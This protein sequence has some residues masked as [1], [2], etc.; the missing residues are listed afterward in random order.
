[1]AVDIEKVRKSLE[2]CPIK[3]VGDGKF[4][5][6]I[7]DERHVRV[8]VPVEGLH[9]NHVGIVYAGT[10]FT[11]MELAAG[12]IFMCTYGLD[13][14]VPIVSNF[15]ISFL[16]P[17]K[18]DLVAEIE[19]TEEEAAERIKPIRERGRG[20]MPVEITLRANGIGVGNHVVYIAYNSEMYF[21]ILTACS[22]IGAVF[23]PISWRMC[24]ESIIELVDATDAKVLFVSK[25]FLEQLET[26][27]HSISGERKIIVIDDVGED[28]AAYSGCLAYPNE[29]ISSADRSGEGC[30]MQIYTSG[31]TS[32]PKGVMLSDNAI[33]SHALGHLTDICQTGNSVYMCVLPLFH[34]SSSGAIAT[35]IAGATVVVLERFRPKVYLKTIEKYKATALSLTPSMFS[36]LLDEIDEGSYDLT[37]V[38]SVIYGA[39]PILAKYIRKANEKL[40]C[41]FYQL[42]GMSEMGP[43]I[44]LL[45]A[46]DHRAKDDALLEKRLKSVGKV[47]LGAKI[48]IV[49]PDGS[50]CPVGRQGEIYAQ[51][52]GQMMCYYNAPDKTASVFSDGW[53]HTG[54]VGYLDEDNYLYLVG[55]MSDMIISGGENV[56]PKSVEE[57]ILALD[58]VENV[59]VVGLKDDHLGEAVTAVI[60]KAPGAELDE[61]TVR[62]WCKGKIAGF[63]KPRKVF[64]VNELPVNSTGKID[65]RK[66]TEMF[67]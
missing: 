45:R 15:E 40:G 38:K 30:L 32:I 39:E 24:A 22:R 3:W 63:M 2:V 64:F 66:L 4:T 18:K 7:L 48:K 29:E 55:R 65:K 49:A 50:K 21:E 28:N 10:M 5:N 67:N 14:F 27:K 60:V 20:R 34:A 6:E 36:A 33:C 43:V 17:T 1:M 13:E 54:D 51:G 16:K 12:A 9:L 35:L 62:N 47:A 31:T 58:G 8:V 53:Y 37:S 56:Y 11:A 26:L 44:T 57:C 46:E 61:A 42:F 59:A 19:W 23:T 25:S 41:D 52:L